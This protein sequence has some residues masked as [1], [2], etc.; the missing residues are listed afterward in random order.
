MKTKGINHLALVC[1]DMAET[2]EWYE[3]VLGLKLV[4]TLE[5]PGGRGQHFFLDMGN[6]IDGIAFFWFPGAAEQDPDARNAVGAMNHLAFDVTPERFDSYR[7]RLVAKGVDVTEAVNHCD[8]LDGGHK[9][10]YDPAT[11]GGDV[12]IRSIYFED[13]NGITLEFAAWT[14]PL[15][16]GDVRHAPATARTLV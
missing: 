9:E 3:R 2:V 6:G 8:S 14:R 12:F 10:D 15:G 11:D 1:R 13:P 5:L 16:E 7:E 4:K